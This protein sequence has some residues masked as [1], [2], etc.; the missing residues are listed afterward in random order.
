MGSHD[1]FVGDRAD[2]VLS[3]GRQETA[4]TGG[5]CEGDEGQEEPQAQPTH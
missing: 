1:L 3:T 4:H 5:H 2:S